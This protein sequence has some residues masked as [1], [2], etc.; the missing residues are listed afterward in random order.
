VDLT[1]VSDWH[2]HSNLPLFHSSC[3]LLTMT[4]KLIFKPTNMTAIMKVLPLSHGVQSL[5]SSLAVW[6]NFYWIFFKLKEGHARTEN[7]FVDHTAQCTKLFQNSHKSQDQHSPSTV[8][9]RYYNCIWQIK[10]YSPSF[11]I[12]S[13]HL[14]NAII[15]AGFPEN[16]ALNDPFANGG[17]FQY[18]KP[19]KLYP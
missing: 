12:A 3:N 14:Q 1:C 16:L 8:L 9:Q 4:M 19:P 15:F 2:I 13:F 10:R 7:F 6:L 11:P 5:N 17:S 18:K